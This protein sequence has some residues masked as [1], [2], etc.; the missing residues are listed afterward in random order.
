MRVGGGG[1]EKIGG[2]GGYSMAACQGPCNVRAAEG[3]RGATFFHIA[4][5]YHS[6]TY[7]HACEGGEDSILAKGRHGRMSEVMYSA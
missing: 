6:F 1:G 2:H 4:S 5:D 3:L 7:G